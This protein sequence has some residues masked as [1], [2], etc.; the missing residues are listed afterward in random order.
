[1]TSPSYEMRSISHKKVQGRQGTGPQD[2]DSPEGGFPFRPL[3]SPYPPYYTL[4][5]GG[6]TTLR[7]SLGSSWVGST[8]TFTPMDLPMRSRKWK[9]LVQGTPHFVTNAFMFQRAA[10]WYE[11][12]RNRVLRA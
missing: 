8:P 6:P 9:P 10:G 5:Y 1:M 7:F 12:V 2:R 11:R 4:K 3:P